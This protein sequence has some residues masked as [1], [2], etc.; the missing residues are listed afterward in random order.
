MARTLYSLYFSPTNSTETIAKTIGKTVA[1]DRQ[2]KQVIFN[3]TLPDKRPAPVTCDPDDVLLFGIPV[4]GCRVP[5]LLA[6]SIAQL[7]G[8]GASAIV[9]AL[10]GNRDYGDA[11]IELADLLEERGFHI[12]AGASF[13]GEHSA[14]SRVGTG[15][16]DADDVALAAQFGHDVAEKLANG[17]ADKPAI[18]GNH[19]Y[20]DAMP[21]VVKRPKTTDDCIQC[22]TCADNCPKGI[23]DPDDPTKVGLGCIACSACIKNCPVGAKYFDDDHTKM[24]INML[25]SRCLARKEP[26]LFL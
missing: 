20:C 16:P 10:Y 1:D 9:L 25:E 2:L 14:T 26:E 11:L 17:A 21:N 23:I 12:L 18:K 5:T 24:I 13:I 7:E 22:G 8:N 19:P 15:R 6:E 4:Y 3:L